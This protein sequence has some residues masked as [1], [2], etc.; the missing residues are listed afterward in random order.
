MTDRI[1]Y[2]VG[3]GVDFK[4]IGT[5]TTNMTCRCHQCGIFFGD[6]NALAEHWQRNGRDSRRCRHR[7]D[8]DWPRRRLEAAKE[9]LAELSARLEQRIAA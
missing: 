2:P 8:G 7:M 3:S 1:Y 9:R 4:T 6:D 5:A